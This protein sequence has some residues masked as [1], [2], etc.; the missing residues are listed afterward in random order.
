MVLLLDMNNSIDQ[1]TDYSGRELYSYLSGVD[2][3][4][5][6]KEADIENVKLAGEVE[7]TAYADP[8]HYLFPVNSKARVY[9]SNAFLSNKKAALVELWNQEHVDKIV[10]NI[11]KAAEAYGILD[12][13]RAYNTISE[14]R[15][16]EDYKDNSIVLDVQGNTIDL[17]TIKTAADLTKEAN[18]FITNLDN[19][20]YEWR[21]GISEQFVKAAENL[22]I[23]ELPDLVVKYAGQ[24]F[25]DIANVKS[26]LER[27]MSKLSN[28]TAIERY[29]ELIKQANDAI[30]SVE[31]VFNLAEFCYFTEKN[32]GLYD[33]PAIARLLGDPVDRMFTLSFEKVAEL[34]DIVEMGGEKFAAADLAKISSDVYEQAFGFKISSKEA[35]FK[36]IAPTLPRSDVALFK[37][38]TGVRAI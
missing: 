25:P 30:E 29:Q 33:K 14:K 27:R 3:P 34:F 1:Q 36:D 2:L 31:D 21:R 10:A 22:G 26:E 8:L 12:D 19:Y 11:E 5:Y 15:A 28:E 13:I 24:Y 32:A 16:T 17:F 6:V 7:K 20:P 4:E 23:D 37:E 9:V 18:R 38:L 35:E